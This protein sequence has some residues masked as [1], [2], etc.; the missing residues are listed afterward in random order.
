[1]NLLRAWITIVNCHEAI[2]KKL[3]C[4]EKKPETGATI[5]CLRAY[6]ITHFSLRQNTHPLRI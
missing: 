4:A 2:L 6:K 5:G 1:M 3:F